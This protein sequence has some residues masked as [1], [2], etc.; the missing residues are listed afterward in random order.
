MGIFDKDGLTRTGYGG[1]THFTSYD[2]SM[3]R[4][5]DIGQTSV[6]GY[7]GR[8]AKEAIEKYVRSGAS[9]AEVMSAIDE[10]ASKWGR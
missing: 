2:A 1:T 10:V 8:T 3:S 5:K 9:E 6:R 4:V 7:Q